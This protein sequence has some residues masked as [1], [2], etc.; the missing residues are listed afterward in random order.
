MLTRERGCHEHLRTVLRVSF[1]LA[2]PLGGVRSALGP[3]TYPGDA[4]GTS[5][6]CGESFP[7]LPRTWESVKPSS[8][9]TGRRTQAATLTE[10]EREKHLGLPGSP[11]GRRL[12]GSSLGPEPGLLC[13]GERECQRP[14]SLTVVPA[15]VGGGQPVESFLRQN[16]DRFP[17]TGR[18]SHLFTSARCLAPQCPPSSGSEGPG[19]RMRP[20]GPER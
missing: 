2:E 13:P 5:V 7:S 14:L 11:A 3:Q 19:I 17:P 6:V 4:A 8:W 16:R 1:D 15:Q 12:P 10:G 18:G 9:A 20:P